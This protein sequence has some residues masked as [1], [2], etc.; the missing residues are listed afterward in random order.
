MKVKEENVAHHQS[1]GT[2]RSR[3]FKPDIAKPVQEDAE[4]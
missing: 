1:T 2:T 4:I 3:T